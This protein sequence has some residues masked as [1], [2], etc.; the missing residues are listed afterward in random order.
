M[1]LESVAE[2]L[3]NR[4]GIFIDPEHASAVAGG[5]IH[6]AF[7]T[8]CQF[9]PVFIKLAQDEL[10]A[11]LAA[12]A[13]GL[14]ALAEASVLRVPNLV[15]FG[16]SADT[17]YLVLEWL[18]FESKSSIANRR[19]G[20][21]LAALHRRSAEGF[22]WRCD[23][24][25]GRT[26]QLNPVITG[27]PEFFATA[28]LEPQL[29]RAETSGAGA[30]MIASVSAVI[31]RLHRLLDH[32]PQPSLI[33]GDLWGGNWGV[34]DD[35]EPVVFDPAV[36]YA[37][38]ECDLAMTHLFGGFDSGFYDAYGSTWALPEGWERRL[39]IYQLYHVLNHFNLFGGGYEQQAEGLAREVG[40]AG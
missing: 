10:A 39:P 40:V 25:I 3:A 15:A 18:D 7:R 21:H 35:D 2:D 19:L 24:V 9:G 1:S 31:D 17:T 13:D 29:R 26:P 12:E 22:G 11:A 5:D 30:R 14:A 37:D 23:N 16:A 28:R 36:H 38:R 32:E 6:S 4:H 8:Q 33:H 20:E 34:I 27:W